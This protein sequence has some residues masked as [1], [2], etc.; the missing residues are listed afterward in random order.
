MMGAL[1]KH[2]PMLR[3]AF[4][5]L[6]PTKVSLNYMAIEYKR[7]IRDEDWILLLTLFMERAWGD[8]SRYAPI[9]KRITNKTLGAVV[10]KVGAVVYAR[11]F[12]MDHIYFMGVP[13][14]LVY[15]GALASELSKYDGTRRPRPYER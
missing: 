3:L 14:R 2:L 12:G 5:A 4:E 1:E 8:E 11:I 6:P 13:K 10:Q 9:V 7:F 15:L